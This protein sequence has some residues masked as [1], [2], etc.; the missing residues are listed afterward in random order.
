MK[1][2]H[3]NQEES[4]SAQMQAVFA[5]IFILQNRFQTTYGREHDD[6]TA[7]QWLMLSMIRL[8]PKPHTLTSIGSCMGCSRQNVKQLATALSTKG[9]VRLVPG[10]QNALI[11]KLTPKAK[12][13]E[14]KMS[15]RHAEVLR[16]LFSD[17]NDEELIML[18]QLYKKLYSGIERIEKSCM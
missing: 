5:S 10:Y 3:D 8:C 9:Y 17:F 14:K 1:E 15:K 12:A 4:S 2:L 6:L 13:Y 16:L 18:N 11:V 7:K